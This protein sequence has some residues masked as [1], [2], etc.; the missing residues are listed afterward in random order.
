[1]YEGFAALYRKYHLAFDETYLDL[2]ESLSVNALRGR[3]PNALQQIGTD[4]ERTLGGK[5]VLS[6][7]RFYLRGEGG[8]MLEAPLLSEGFRKL[9]SILRLLQNGELRETGLLLWDEP[10]ANLNPKLTVL[11]A[12]AL[13]RLAKSKV[14]V[15]LATHDYL[16]VETLNMMARAKKRNATTRFFVFERPTATGSVE[17]T[18]AD[19]LD[20]LPSNPIRREF[21]AHYDRVRGVE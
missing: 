10:E 20:D 17:V 18:G 12:Q 7:S 8:S 2:A 5:V 15:V 19:D 11:V 3:L 1:M 9:A 16:L 21:L 13:T 4:L 6:G 14:Q